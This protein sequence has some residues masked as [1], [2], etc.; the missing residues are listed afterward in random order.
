MRLSNEDSTRGAPDIPA[1]FRLRQEENERSAGETHT[2]THC[3]AGKAENVIT[4]I[5]V[6]SIYTSE[7]LFACGLAQTSSDFLKACPPEI[8]A[9]GGVLGTKRETEKSKS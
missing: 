6:H 2:Q 7:A 8:V 9:Q 3:A 1:A 4:Y 5:D